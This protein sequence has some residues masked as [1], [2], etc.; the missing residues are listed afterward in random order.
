MR[1]RY[2]AYTLGL[3]DYVFAT[4]HPRTRPADLSLDPR[5]TWTGLRVEGE[6]ADWVEFTASYAT[7]DGAAGTLHERSRFTTRA[8]RWVYVDGDVQD[9]S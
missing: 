4:W 8:G 9:A 5:L 2:A 3:E 1:A 7:A 6:G